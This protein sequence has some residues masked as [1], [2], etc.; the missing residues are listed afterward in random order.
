MENQEPSPPKI[1]YSMFRKYLLGK[2]KNVYYENQKEIC[3]FIVGIEKELWV[4]L[5]TSHEATFDPVL[6]NET[7]LEYLCIS[8]LYFT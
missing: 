3:P 2:I 8:R 4:R 6:K 5:Y 1:N 7:K